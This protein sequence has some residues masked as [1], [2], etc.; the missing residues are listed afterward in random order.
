MTEEPERTFEQLMVRLEEV[1]SSLETQK[2]P[3]EESLR[4]FEEGV[5][6]SRKATGRLET[7]E[8]RIEELLANGA[9]KPLV[10]E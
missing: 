10:K 7:A 1:V 2:L 4:L 6:L 9:T 5:A 8:R 3:L